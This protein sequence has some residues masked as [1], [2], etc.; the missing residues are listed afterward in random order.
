MTVSNS[1][2]SYEDCYRIMDAALADER[3]VRVKLRDINGATFF[4]MRCHQA[5]KIDRQ[6][7]EDTYEKGD[8]RYKVSQYDRLILRIRADAE[9]VWVKIEQNAVIPGE[10]ESLSTGE[11]L[12]I[13]LPMIPYE[14]Q[15]RLPA[16]PPPKALT[17]NELADAFNN[18]ST[19]SEDKITIIPPKVGFRRL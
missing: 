12:E 10:V 6:R 14:P 18:I 17:D 9:G 15:Q 5:R 11:L 7:S 8:P 4:R 16:P 13:G 1:P 2:L 3:G 19:V